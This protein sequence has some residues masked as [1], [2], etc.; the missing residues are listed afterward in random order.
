MRTPRVCV[1]SE[2]KYKELDPTALE[3]VRCCEVLFVMVVK[4]GRGHSFV[5]ITRFSRLHHP[6]TLDGGNEEWKR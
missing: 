4:S 6:I 2:F 3:L 1:D 5:P